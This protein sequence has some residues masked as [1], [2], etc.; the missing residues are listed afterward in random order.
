MHSSTRGEG[1]TVIMV[2]G[3]AVDHRI[4]TPLDDA[5][6]AAGWRRLYVDLPGMGGSAGDPVDSTDD[7]LDAVREVVA[8]EIGDEPFAVLGSSYGGMVA[9]CLAARLPGQVA[10]VGLLCPLVGEVRD[11]SPRHVARADPALLAA[12]DPQD[13]EAFAEVAVVQSPE[14]WALFRD[15]VLPGLRAADQ[16]ALA[17]IRSRY[18]P[19]RPP[20]ADAPFA[21]PTLLVAGRHDHVVGYRDALRLLADHPRATVAVLDDAGHNAHLER[22]DVVGAL[23]TEWLG[24]AAAAVSG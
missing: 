13:A 16:D 3:F 24:R 21:G 11:L 20:E 15:H 6:A 8:R 17:R 10:G 9:R 12:L 22:P 7:V 1:R 4:L 14:T 18:T 2:H 19:S 23:V 5:V